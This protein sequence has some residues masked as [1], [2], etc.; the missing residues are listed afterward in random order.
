MSPKAK[1]LLVLYL[2]RLWYLQKVRKTMLSENKLHTSGILT[3]N[4]RHENTIAIVITTI[5]VTIPTPATMT[6]IPP[7]AQVLPTNTM[8]TTQTP[9]LVSLP[10]S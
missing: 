4:V 9:S 6:L 8:M 10:G 3:P 7:Q 5:V 2:L 1:M